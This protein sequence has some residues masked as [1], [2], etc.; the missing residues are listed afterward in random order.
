M[1]GVDFPAALARY[2][3]P[4]L[5]LNGQRDWVHR[6]AERAYARAARNAR[7]QIIARAGHIASLDQP[8]AFTAAVRAF[9]SQATTVPSTPII[10]GRGHLKEPTPC[11]KQ[12]SLSTPGAWTPP[13]A[14][15]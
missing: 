1:R 6:T 4:T 12:S 11:L 9:R 5:I 14:S 15:R 10:G 7:I 3:G 8:E 2:P 13:S